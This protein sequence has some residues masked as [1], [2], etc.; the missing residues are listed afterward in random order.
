MSEP[1]GPGAGPPPRPVLPRPPR[2]R[3]AALRL[4]LLGIPFDELRPER[5]G[6]RAHEPAA[7]ERQA[8]IAAAFW[9]GYHA[10]LADP[11]PQPVRE[12]IEGVER[13]W[14]GFACE[15]VGMALELLDAL[16]PSFSKRR[17]RRLDAVLAGPVGVHRYL[18]YLGVGF[19]LA[20]LRRRPRPVLERLDP[21]CR[22]LIFDGYGFYHG[23]FGWRRTLI[24]HRVPRSLAGCGYGRRVFDHGLGRSLWFVEAMAPRVIAEG[25]EGFP[26]ERRG[27]LWTGVGLASAYA[28]G[29]P[30]AGLAELRERSGRWAPDLLQGAAFA[31]T[32]RLEADDF[33]AHTDEACRALCGAGAAELGALTLELSRDLP[34]DGG[35]LDAPEPAWELWRRRVRREL[36]SGRNLSSARRGIAS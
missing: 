30:P 14:R 36:G 26:E 20:R 7:A 22:W 2:S 25:I 31:A 35:A 13:G 6:F 34:E 1:L 23:F 11:R 32:A 12:T 8:R 15:G 33:A 17:G 27:D 28:G 5:R 18:L 4:R 24:E 3:L 21:L 9:V 16:T 19:T 29:L 10:A